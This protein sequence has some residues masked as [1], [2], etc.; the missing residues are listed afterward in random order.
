MI[1]ES[2]DT[3]VINK[4]IVIGH[5][6]WKNVHCVWNKSVNASN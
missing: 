3:C 1:D 5:I 2:E 6:C 4:W